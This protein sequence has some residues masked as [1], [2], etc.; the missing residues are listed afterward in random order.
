MRKRYKILTPQVVAGSQDGEGHKCDTEE[1]IIRPS[2]SA[3]VDDNY[4]TKKSPRT[5]RR[6]G[7]VPTFDD[8]TQ[9]KS[10]DKSSTKAASR[11]RKAKKSTPNGVQLTF[12]V[13]PPSQ[14]KSGKKDCLS[15]G[16]IRIPIKSVSDL[17]SREN[18]VVV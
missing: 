17:P 16:R 5:K 15:I 10:G 13:T 2:R 3:T 18:S 12:V 9:N 4:G 6:S 11:S 8:E 14:R 7:S 1:S